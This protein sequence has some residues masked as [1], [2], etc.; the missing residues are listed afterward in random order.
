MSVGEGHAWTVSMRS[1][2]QEVSSALLPA[3]SSRRD[4]E[5]VLA[6]PGV[7]VGAALLSSMLVDSRPPQA[8]QSVRADYHRQGFLAAAVS[9]MMGT[10]SDA[11]APAV[12]ELTVRFN[13]PYAVVAATA[14]MAPDVGDPRLRRTKVVADDAW[15]GV[16][17]FS[18]WVTPSALSG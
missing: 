16:P 8:C 13:R 7:R 4:Q 10:L 3:W 1:E 15:D 6:A 9:A 14:A 11:P 18:A 2:F 17:V 12:R 5:D